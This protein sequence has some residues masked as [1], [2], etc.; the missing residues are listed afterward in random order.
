MIGDTKAKE[1]IY[2]ASNIKAQEALEIGLLNKVVEPEALMDEAM[3]MANKIVS[4]APLAVAFA[5][6]AINR[7]RQVDIDTAMTLESSMVSILFSSEDVHEGMKA[8]VEKRKPEYK[9]K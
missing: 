1:L 7:G 3:A 6:E 8:F 4:N 9:G 2:T 5:K